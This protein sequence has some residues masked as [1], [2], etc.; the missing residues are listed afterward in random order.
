MRLPAWTPRLLTQPRRMVPGAAGILALILIGV[1]LPSKP[2]AHDAAGVNR[3]GDQVSANGLSGEGAVGP[4]GAGPNGTAA[5]GDGAGA[6]GPNGVG[7]KTGGKTQKGVGGPGGSTNP[8]ERLG[9]GVTATDVNMVFAYQHDPCGQDVNAFIDKAVPNRDPEASITTSI[10]YFNKHAGEIFGPDLPAELRPHVNA[11]GFYGRKIKPTIVDDH[12]PSCA[13]QSKVDAEHASSLKPFA[14]LG[15]TESTWDAEMTSHGIVRVTSAFALDRYFT[16]KRPYLWETVSSASVINRFLAGYTATRLKPFNSTDTGDVRTGNRPRA[17]GIIHLDDPETGDDVADLKAQLEKR[18][19]TVAKTAKYAPNVGT[20]G[21]ES[22]NI[23]LQMIDAHVT[24]ILMVMD[25]IAAE[26]MTQ[27]ADTQKFY[28]EWIT[29][30]YGLMDNNLGPRQFMSADQQK[31]TFGISV[32]FPSKPLPPEQTEE[33][34]AWQA[35]HPGT[36]PP[37]DFAAWYI[38]IKLVLRGIAFA[39]PTLNAFTLES[40]YQRYCNPC[41]RTDPKI[42]LTAF[43]PGDYT[44]IDDAHMQVWDPEAPDYGAP[45]SAYT[46]GQPPKGAYQFLEDGR[47]YRSFD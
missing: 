8:A 24:T 5:P 11:N 35:E 28:P 27:A 46:N 16:S 15:G 18:G 42:P 6:V 17:F 31:H 41:R 29:N 10:A 21:A 23:I 32:A 12:G 34:K 25:P 26:F 43:G 36:E 19:V 7:G 20:I 37:G 3:G 39:G 47:R 38:E 13:E 33:Y 2:G 4:D 9:P 14:S 22:T 44:G 40:G 45:K 1:Y 30:T